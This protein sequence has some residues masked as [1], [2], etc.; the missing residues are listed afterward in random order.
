MPCRSE[1]TTGKERTK[2]ICPSKSIVLK[3][4]PFQGKEGKKEGRGTF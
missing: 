2:S 4:Q 3:K 1:L